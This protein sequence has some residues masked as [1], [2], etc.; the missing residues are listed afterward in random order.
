MI[1]IFCDDCGKELTKEEHKY[2]ISMKFN[3]THIVNFD[4]EL[5]FCK[6]CSEKFNKNYKNLFEQYKK[7]E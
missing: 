7:G 2:L 6:D 1:K 4:K 5:T 3:G